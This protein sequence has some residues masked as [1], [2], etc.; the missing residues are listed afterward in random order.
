MQTHP[1]V[2]QFKGTTWNKFTK[3]FGVEDYTIKSG[4]T[5]ASVR[6]TEFS[7]SGGK[8]YTAEGIVEVEF[9][10]EKYAVEENKVVEVINGKV[11]ER[12]ANN[13]ERKTTEWQRER[14]IKNLEKIR[15]NE[16]ERHSVVMNIV[17]KKYSVTDEKIKGSIK[18]VDEGKYD[19]DSLVKKSPVETD[20]I[21][22]LAELTKKIQ[23]LKKERK[24]GR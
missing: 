5:F 21:K 7:F 13:Y 19:V 18:D 10:G 11:K 24:E 17:K 12:E 15:E 3:L 9:A 20:S 1:V 16:L 14:V 8:I 6:G 4:T 23:Q 2:E 22:K